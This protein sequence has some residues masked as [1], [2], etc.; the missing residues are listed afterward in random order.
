MNLLIESNLIKKIIK[1][2]ILEAV[3][4]G[5]EQRFS[6]TETALLDDLENISF[7]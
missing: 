2:S 6:S 5:R 4:M 1:Q 7:M 3:G